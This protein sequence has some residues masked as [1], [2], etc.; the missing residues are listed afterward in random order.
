MQLLNNK[1]RSNALNLTAFTVRLSYQL[2]WTM[3]FAALLTGI[4]CAKALATEQIF[5][6]SA[7]NQAPLPRSNQD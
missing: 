1:M 4:S 6:F 3:F 7:H 2:A 5:V